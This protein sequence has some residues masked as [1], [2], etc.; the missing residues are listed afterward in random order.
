MLFDGAGVVVVVADLNVSES[1]K[2][3]SIAPRQ[4]PAVRVWR[5][6][7]VWGNNDKFVLQTNP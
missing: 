7:T 1:R 5:K 2:S 4:S 3:T 6:M